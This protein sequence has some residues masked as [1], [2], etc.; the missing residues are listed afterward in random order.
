MLADAKNDNDKVPTV[1][2]KKRLKEITGDADYADELE[3]VQ[4]YLKL[5]DDETAEVKR[6][7]ELEISL[8]KKLLEKYKN[9]TPDEIK[10]LVVDDKWMTTI[11]MEI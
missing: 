3:V 9:L 10:E 8:D 5:S 11:E 7:K 4:T 1:S 6:I 2:V